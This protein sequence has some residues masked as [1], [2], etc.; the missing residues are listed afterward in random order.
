MQKKLL[1]DRG[2]CWKKKS[3]SRFRARVRQARHLGHKAPGG[4]RSQGCASLHP[5]HLTRFT[6]GLALL[7]KRI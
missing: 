4:A 3:L 7:L 6:L 2:V 1:E 5:R